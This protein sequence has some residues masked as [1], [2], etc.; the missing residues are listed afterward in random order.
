MGMLPTTANADRDGWHRHH[1]HHHHRHH[2]HGRHHHYRSYRPYYVE[3]YYG[4]GYRPYYRQYHRHGDSVG[5]YTPW[6]SF[7]YYD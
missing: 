2:G 5:V 1:R 3:P 7:Y 6:G 4:Y